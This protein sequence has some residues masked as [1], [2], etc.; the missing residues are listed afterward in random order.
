MRFQRQLFSFRQCQ[1]LDWR[2]HRRE[3]A[4]LKDENALAEALSEMNPAF[5]SAS[6]G[7]VLR[8]IL[9]QTGLSPLLFVLNELRALLNK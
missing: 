7:A 8:K 5:R 4:F 9:V 6:D 1:R 3:C 2:V